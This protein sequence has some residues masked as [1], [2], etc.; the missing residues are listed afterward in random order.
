MKFYVYM[1][2]MWRIN[3]RSVTLQNTNTKNIVQWVSNAY[4]RSLQHHTKR[5]D[6]LVQLFQLY[7]MKKNSKIKENLRAQNKQKTFFFSFISHSKK[8]F[9]SFCFHHSSCH[10]HFGVN[11]L[12]LHNE[13]CVSVYI[14]FTWTSC[15][16]K[17]FIISKNTQQTNGWKNAG[18]SFYGI[19]TKA[20][21]N[22]TNVCQSLNWRCV[23]YSYTRFI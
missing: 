10:F 15:K 19:K 14:L 16:E 11:V 1:H 2:L 12:C 22:R 17:P 7:R 8:M 3:F 20:R 4:W 13:Y 18:K 9:F 6:N 23:F 21:T 5:K